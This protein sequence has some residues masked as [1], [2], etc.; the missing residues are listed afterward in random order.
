MSKNDLKDTLMRLS[1]EQHSPG[2]NRPSV[3]GYAM[4]DEFGFI[5]REA[6]AEAN[7]AYEEWAHQPCGDA[8]AV[9]RAAQ[10]RADAAQDALANCARQ[11]GI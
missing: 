7:R 3:H 8:Y 6:Q 9:Y 5:R 10:D 4:L 2:V 11:L 1:N